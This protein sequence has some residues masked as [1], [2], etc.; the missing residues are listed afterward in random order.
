MYRG[1]NTERG[2]MSILDAARQILA[3][4]KAPLHVK[5]LTSRM[6]AQ[7][8]WV[9]P[10]KTPTDSVSAALAVD[11]KRRGQGSDF[12]RTQPGIYGL[13]TLSG[14]GVAPSGSKIAAVPLPA[15]PVAPPAVA[16]SVSGP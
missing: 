13:R 4:A 3:E 2:A 16:I 12:E 9:T 11:I 15:P 8:L 14:P 1:R 6:L 5:D 10:G 7:K